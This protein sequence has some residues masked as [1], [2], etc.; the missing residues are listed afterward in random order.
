MELKTAEDSPGYVAS[1]LMHFLK[2]SRW[3]RTLGLKESFFILLNKLAPALPDKAILGQL[4]I[5]RKYL[6]K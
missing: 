6:P 2:V 3:E 1:Q 5:I 4:P